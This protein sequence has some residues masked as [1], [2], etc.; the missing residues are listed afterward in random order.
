MSMLLS[1]SIWVSPLDLAWRRRARVGWYCWWQPEIRVPLTSWGRLVVEIYHD[2]P[3]FQKHPNPWLFEI[4][5]INSINWWFGLVVPRGFHLG[6][7][8]S[9][10][11]GI[12]KIQSTNP[13]H[14]FTIS[15]WYM[16]SQFFK[17][18]KQ[19]PVGF[20]RW[21]QIRAKT[22]SKTITRLAGIS[23]YFNRCLITSSNGCFSVVML[24]FGGVWCD[25]IKFMVGCLIGKLA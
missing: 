25:I 11:K 14:Q 4:F 15:W 1:P 2:L 13:N 22:S 20:D 17:K 8:N 9:F 23:R 5:S 10:N 19:V 24:L 12:Q 6:V 16:A 3:R 18:K 21:F 7:S